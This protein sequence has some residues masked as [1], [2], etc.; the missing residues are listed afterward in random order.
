MP[1]QQEILNQPADFKLRIPLPKMMT[2]REELNLTRLAATRDPI[3]SEYRYRLAHLLF[4]LDVFDEAIDILRRLAS[5][6]SEF[7]VFQML[8]TALLA[9]ET[10][11]DSIAAK[12]FAKLAVDAAGDRYERSR[13]LALLGKVHARLSETQE[14][15]DRL[16]EALKE[17]VANKDAYKRLAMLD[18]QAGHNQEA[19]DYAEQMVA[20]GVCHCRVLGVRPLAFAKLGRMNEAREAFGLGRFLHQC[21]LPPPP[22]WPTIE[23][24]NRELAAELTN[25]PGIRRER[26]GTASAHTWRVDEPALARSRFVPELQKLIVREATAYVARLSG[27]DHPWLRARPPE[28]SLHSWS[29]MTDGDGFEE[30]HVHQNGWLSGAYYVDVPD[31]IVHGTGPKGC[32]LFGLPNGIVGEDRHT[33]FGNQLFRPN[34]G[35]LLLFPSHAFHRTFA[36][37]GDRRRICFAFDIAPDS[38]VN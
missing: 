15:R 6:V 22:A 31:F 29:V 11:Q 30:W 35:L 32:I 17:N 19:S 33:E 1:S 25:H 4:T 27:D 37:Q 36:H 8:A 2:T 38:E 5:E 12:Q 24:F 20:N 18:F 3:V 26:Y 10:A 23:A 28:S 16:V 21:I 14:S 9:R 7:R 34:S 13:A